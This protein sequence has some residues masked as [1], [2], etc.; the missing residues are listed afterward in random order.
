MSCAFP[1]RDNRSVIG[2]H[3]GIFKFNLINTAVVAVTFDLFDTLVTVSR[4]ADPAAA[5]ASELQTRGV[6]VPSDWE[7]AYR[8]VHVESQRG[9]EVPL[10]THVNAA[11]QSR[12]VSAPAEYIRHAV[13]AA[14]DPTVQT[15][16][17]AITA[18]ETAVAN[19]P[20]GILSNCSVSQLVHRTLMRS[21]IDRSLFDAIVTSVDCGWRKPHPRAFQAVA[22][23]LRVDPTSLIHIG[24]NPE[25][26]GGIND[27]GGHFHNITKT[28]LGQI[29][30]ALDGDFNNNDSNIN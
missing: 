8:T 18:V 15:R 7:T 23:S 6:T 10:S 12:D 19:G 30:T 5:V 4:P 27:V 9:S 22:K 20:V 13:T 16:P 11:L 3:V 2:S 21:D 28:S 26:D 1:N 24:D 14:F 17:N 29:N 25:T